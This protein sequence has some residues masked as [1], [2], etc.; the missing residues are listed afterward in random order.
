M[1]SLFPT[2]TISDS[3]VDEGPV[4]LGV[5]REAPSSQESQVVCC[6]P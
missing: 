4:L 1:Q 6:P 2:L 3:P 5:F